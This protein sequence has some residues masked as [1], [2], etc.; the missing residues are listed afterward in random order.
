MRIDARRQLAKPGRKDFLYRRSGE[1]HAGIPLRSLFSSPL[2]DKRMVRHNAPA[3]G[4]RPAAAVRKPANQAKAPE[5]PSPF[6]AYAP[7]MVTLPL[8]GPGADR[9][10]SPRGQL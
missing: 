2:H 10:T 8:S 6:R 1:T 9:A 3:I 4:R 7:R 5:A